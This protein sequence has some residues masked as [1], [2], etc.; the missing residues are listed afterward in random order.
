M[1]YPVVLVHDPGE[2]YTVT[3]PGL[4]G[5]ISEG[6]TEAEALENIRSAIEEYLAVRDELLQGGEIREVEVAG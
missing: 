5:C 2:G 3:V 1:K 4:P 6:K